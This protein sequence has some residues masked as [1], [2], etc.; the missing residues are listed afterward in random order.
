MSSSE[1][2]EYERENGCKLGT[3]LHQTECRLSENINFVFQL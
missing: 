3:E 1:L 2:W